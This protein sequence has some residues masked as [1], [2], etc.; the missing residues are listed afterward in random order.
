VLR[1]PY[2]AGAAHAAQP[3]AP[4]VAA[5]Q[6][7]GC[8][9]HHTVPALVDLTITVPVGA[10]IALVGPNGAGKSTLLK[11]I[12]GLLPLQQGTLSLFGHPLA[13][14]RQRVAYLAQRS[15][16]DWRFPMTVARLVGTGCYTRRGWLHGLGSSERQTVAAVM[17]Q[18]QIDH[19]ADRQIGQLSGGQQQRTLLARA[20]AQEADLLL[21]DEPLNAVDA[22]TRAVITEVLDDL[23]VQRRTV[24]IATHD[25]GRLEHDFDGAFYLSEGHEV[26]PP[27]GSFIG[28]QVGQMK[29]DEDRPGRN[30][31]S[32][33]PPN[34]QRPNHPPPPIS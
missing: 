11:L 26:A 5:V 6:I 1:F 34:D 4:A 21:L 18:L 23:K 10:R 25:L 7:S 29:V 32:A 31:A 3:G 9:P 12:V 22:E 19:L 20:L 15:E 30:P 27:P 24:L 28:I 13:Q 2:T 8:Y 17:A 33:T 16:I 14:V